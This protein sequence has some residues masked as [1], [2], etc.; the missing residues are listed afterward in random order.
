MQFIRGEASEGAAAL[1]EA[2]KAALAEGKRVLWFFSGGS[3]IPLTVGIM[4][5][6]PAELTKNLVIM[7][8]DERFGPVGHADSN[9][10]QLLDSG[11]D[12]KRATFVPILDGSDEQTTVRRFTNHLAMFLSKSNVIIGQLGMGADG[13]IAGILPHSPAADAHDP[14]VIYDGNDGRRRITPTFDV[15]RRLTSTYLFAFGSNKKP[16]LEELHNSKMPL[17]EQPAQILKD[18]PNVYVYNDQI[19]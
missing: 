3:N 9:V 7:P 11:F 8:I 1:A 6:L 10:Q 5:R 2:L 17:T 12:S 14:A 16:A 18:M 13:H 15:L 4:G 19:A